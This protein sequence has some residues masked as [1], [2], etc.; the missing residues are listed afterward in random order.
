MAASET[1]KLPNSIGTIVELNRLSREAEQVDETLRQAGL[2]NGGSAT[3]LP[4]VSRSMNELLEANNLNVLHEKDRNELLKILQYL[5]THA[6]SVQISFGADPSADFTKKLITWMR[7][8]LHP[9]LLLKIGL[10][11][12]IG[13]GCVLRTDSKYFDFSLRQHMDAQREI[14]LNKLRAVS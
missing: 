6:P 14:L 13:A 2:R 8:E 5:Q 12:S 9:Y 3:S 11:P 7:S 10:Q 1:F 4:K